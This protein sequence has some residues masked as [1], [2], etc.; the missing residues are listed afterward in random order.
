MVHDSW[1]QKRHCPLED[2]SLA[3][4]A[5]G[6]SPLS[7]WREHKG[8]LTRCCWS[9]QPGGTA[10]RPPC[11]AAGSHQ[12]V[13]QAAAQPRAQCQVAGSK[14]LG[15]T[16]RS[17]FKNKSGCILHLDAFPSLSVLCVD[18][19]AVCILIFEGEMLQHC[20]SRE[21]AWRCVLPRADGCLQLINGLGGTAEK[22]EPAA[23]STAMPVK[24]FAFFPS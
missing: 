23:G 6:V 22:G 11:A 10:R 7:G 15:S 9:W 16:T 12:R 21:A 3:A 4:L 1:T 8:A 14:T 13:P 2:S 24:H 18:R 17:A 20:G 5:V 19:Y